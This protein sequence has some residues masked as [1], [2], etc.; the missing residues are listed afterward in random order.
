MHCF[1]LLKLILL[2]FQPVIRLYRVPFDAFDSPEET[3]EDL[4]SVQGSDDG[5]TGITGL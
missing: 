4:V 3:E 5:I 2:C 1:W